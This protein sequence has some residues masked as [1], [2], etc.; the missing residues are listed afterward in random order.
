MSPL[1]YASWGWPFLWAHKRWNVWD[2]EGLSL[3][4]S[5]S[6]TFSL[7]HF[8]SLTLSLSEKEEEDGNIWPTNIEVWRCHQTLIY[9]SC[10]HCICRT[11]TFNHLGGGFPFLSVLS[12]PPKISRIR[13]VPI[14]STYPH[15]Y[16]KNMYCYFTTQVKWHLIYEA[17]LA[18]LETKLL[19][20]CL[21]R[22]KCF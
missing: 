12:S 22:C 16:T 19:Y 10:P 20:F 11:G 3:S 7:S 17:F 14:I 6:L 18:T 5:L 13:T 2:L 15:L 9:S 8:L 4:F 21:Q 1:S